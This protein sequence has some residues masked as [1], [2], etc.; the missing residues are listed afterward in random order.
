MTRTELQRRSEAFI[1]DRLRRYLPSGVGVYLFGSRAR[2]TASWNSDYDLW[3]DAEVPER[4]IHDVLE[5]IDDSF[6]PFKVDIVT[7]SGL[8]GQF[9]A[10]VKSEAIRWM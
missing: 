3:I 10:R 1:R 5:E 4:V 7:T 6:V 9:A 2:R 8:R